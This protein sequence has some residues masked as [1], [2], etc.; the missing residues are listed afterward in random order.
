[1]QGYRRR[2]FTAEYKRRILVEADACS[3]P[4]EL[5]ALLRR[6]KL[7]SSH[8]VAWR[9]AR[10]RAELAALAPQKRGPKPK[11][12]ASRQGDTLVARERESGQRDREIKRLQAE[13]ARLQ[14]ICETQRKRI[15]RLLD[16]LRTAILGGNGKSSG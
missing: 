11:V 12:I 16:E 8:L 2:R 6:E 3:R 15:A 1:M 5:S 7:Y 13:N 14:E 10:A 9:R 4:G